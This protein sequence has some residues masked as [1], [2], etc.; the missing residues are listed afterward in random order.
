MFNDQLYLIKNGIEEKVDQLKQRLKSDSY[1]TTNE[2]WAKREVN[3][4]FM[5]QGMLKVMKS[6]KRFKNDSVY[7][8]K[9]IAVFELSNIFTERPFQF[10]FKERV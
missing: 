5:A 1:N 6:R 8:A 2:F 7:Y 10:R 3:K 4:D 9:K